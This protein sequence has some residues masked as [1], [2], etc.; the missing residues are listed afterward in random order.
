MSFDDGY[1]SFYRSAAVQNWTGSAGAGR[2]LGRY[3]GTE[4]VDFGGLMTQAF[5][6]IWEMVREL[7]Q[8]PL[9]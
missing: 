7:A 1:S 8:S 2:Q 9:V 4:K 3:A 6:A 5:A